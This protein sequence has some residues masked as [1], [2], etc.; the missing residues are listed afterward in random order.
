M[1]EPEDLLT[2]SEVVARL[3]GAGLYKDDHSRSSSV[4]KFM[5][6]G[7]LT[8]HF[9]LQPGRE[10][11]GRHD[12]RISAA[13]LEQFLASRTATT[14]PPSGN[15]RAQADGR[16]AVEELTARIGLLMQERQTDRVTWKRQ[17][18][19]HEKELYELRR[20]LLDLEHQARLAGIDADAV[21][22]ELQDEAGTRQTYENVI[23]QLV[24]PEDLRDLLDHN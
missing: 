10:R 17:L 23:T 24:G 5:Q 3:R 11:A 8:D 7:V 20:K 2:L 21:R 15:A 6:N 19:D 22:E 9:V 14:Q 12:K 18:Q 4:Q 13:A 1:D 16:S